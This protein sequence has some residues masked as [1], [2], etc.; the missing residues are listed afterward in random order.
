MNHKI[1]DEYYD[2]LQGKALDLSYKLFGLQ[3]LLEGYN[4]ESY[5][6]EREERKASMGLSMIIADLQDQAHHLY[7]KLDV[8]ERPDLPAFGSTTTPM[9]SDHTFEVA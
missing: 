9:Q 6:S 8:V 5:Y 2:D 4:P 3:R 7:V 1:Y